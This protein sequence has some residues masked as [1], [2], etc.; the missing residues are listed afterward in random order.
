MR[1]LW[2]LDLATEAKAAEAKPQNVQAKPSRI[3]FELIPKNIGAE[4]L[5]RIKFLLQIFRFPNFRETLALLLT[6]SV[7]YFI[8]DSVSYGSLLLIS[9]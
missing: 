7:L 1:E 5:D 6:T 8:T 3:L 9:C 4:S 2:V